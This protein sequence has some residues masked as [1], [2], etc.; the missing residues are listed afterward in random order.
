MILIHTHIIIHVD[1]LIII[2]FLIVIY[3][4]IIIITAL[5]FIIYFIFAVLTFDPSAW[6]LLSSIIIDIAL[7]FPHFIVLLNLLV[8]LWWFL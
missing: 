4:I 3:I 6:T 5:I 2:F 7:I 8:F 1:I